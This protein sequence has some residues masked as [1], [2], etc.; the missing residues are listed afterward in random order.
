MWPL[1]V[2]YTDSSQPIQ[3]LLILLGCWAAF[4]GCVV[5]GKNRQRLHH[6]QREGAALPGG[7]ERY[8]DHCMIYGLLAPCHHG[9][10]LQVCSDVEKS[11]L[12]SS[13]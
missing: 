2:G 3:S 6:L 9:W 10:V 8:A 4:C 12:E 11:R 1:Y 5:Y 7:G 13:N